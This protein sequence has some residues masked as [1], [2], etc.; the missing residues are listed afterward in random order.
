MATAINNWTKLLA[1]TDDALPLL[2]K[3]ERKIG[4]LERGRILYRTNN[5]ASRIFI[6][7]NELLHR[8]SEF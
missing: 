2:L 1:L 6:A 3:I 8:V 4:R 5:A 7:A